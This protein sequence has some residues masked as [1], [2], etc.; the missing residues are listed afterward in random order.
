MALVIKEGMVLQKAG[1]Q[2]GVQRKDETPFRWKNAGDDSRA[3]NEDAR[4]KGSD[5]PKQRGDSVG[6]N[7][8]LPLINRAL[9]SNEAIANSSKSIQTGRERLVSVTNTFYL[10]DVVERLMC[11]IHSL[12]GTCSSTKTIR[13]R[14]AR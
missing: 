4:V 11:L 9:I 13:V 14:E 3:R 5:T 7:F 8:A 1:V 12:P 6:K 2:Q 10:P